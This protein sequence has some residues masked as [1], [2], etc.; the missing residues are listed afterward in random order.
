[1]DHVKKHI[2]FD[3]SSYIFN[4][5]NFM[6]SARRLM[7]EISAIR[8][9]YG[10]CTHTLNNYLQDFIRARFTDSAIFLRST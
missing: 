10:C 1:M 8:W 9:A 4:S 5:C 2:Q 6:L 7:M 3:C